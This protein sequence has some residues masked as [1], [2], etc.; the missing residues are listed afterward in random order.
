MSITKM[1]KQDEAKLI[2]NTEKVIE[3]VNN[4]LDPTEAVIKVASSENLTP[5]I[6]QRILEAYNQSRTL[7]E[8][9]E[10]KGSARLETFPIANADAVRG[11]LFPDSTPSKIHEKTASVARS[12]YGKSTP[13]YFE[14]IKA[15]NLRQ[16]VVME[17]TASCGG[18]SAGQLAAITINKRKEKNK[19]DLE[20]KAAY[21]LEQELK[22]DKENLN[23]LT[24]SLSEKVASAL[25]NSSDKFH[26]I[27]IALKRQFGSS[28]EPIIKMAFD[29][30]R[31]MR[32]NQRRAL[33][34]ELDASSY[35]LS[36]FR[37]PAFGSIENVINSATS[38]HKKSQELKRL[39]GEEKTAF[40]DMTRGA[41]SGLYSAANDF[42]GL[43]EKLYNKEL[44][45]AVDKLQDPKF[46]DHLNQIKVQAM[47]HDLMSNDEV[48]SSYEGDK[49]VDLFNQ[50]YDI[51][52]DV[53][54]KPAIMRD[55]LRRGLVNGGIE[56]L[57][58]GQ[59]ST[60]NKDLSIAHK[61]YRR[62]YK[63]E[64][65]TASAKDI[66][67]MNSAGKNESLQS[68]P[69]HKKMLSGVNVAADN[70]RQ[71]LGGIFKGLTTGY[72]T[73]ANKIN[74][75]LDP[76]PESVKPETKVGP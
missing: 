42:K 5:T 57:E 61:N 45:K 65:M 4:G 55:L 28:I 20:K 49:V 35:T 50:I 56:A 17:K 9:S 6:T 27:E 23:Q 3:L 62:S 71:G 10:K 51:A 47:L 37:P 75:N 74:Q 16:S 76:N 66:R 60:I 69:S 24:Q 64:D 43:D 36:D 44:D 7:H 52:P 13:N 63:L 54:S 32:L 1:S 34:H 41:I 31:L 22:R 14:L 18:M 33:P 15:A 2:Q 21:D 12:F 68:E 58:L 40:F 67:E 70:I 53:A 59:V 38:F 72:N 19:K 46:R 11:R 25:L 26:E 48:I 30:S 8:L 29:S 39:K 73:A